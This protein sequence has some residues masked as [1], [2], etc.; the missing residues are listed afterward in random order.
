MSRSA[1][2][3]EDAELYRLQQF[4]LVKTFFQEIL[5]GES[6]NLWD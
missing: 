1:F 2:S 5:A 3:S 6:P 4:S